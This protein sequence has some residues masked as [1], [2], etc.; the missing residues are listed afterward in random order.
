ML[1]SLVFSSIFATHV[2]SDTIR[3]E[4]RFRE[5]VIGKK[6]VSGNA[7]IVITED[8]KFSGV[9]NQN[10][11][12]RGAWIWHSKYWCRNLAVGSQQWQQD[13]QVV[14]LD[15]KKLTFIRE[16]GKGLKSEWTIQ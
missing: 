12:I 13:C 15:G 14:K 16:K 10:E 1:F 2:A 7:W 3:T 5:T 9:S 4:K 8:G 6:L 11:K